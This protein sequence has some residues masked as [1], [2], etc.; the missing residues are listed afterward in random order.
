MPSCE[1]PVLSRCGLT[2]IGLAIRDHGID[3]FV[4]APEAH[5]AGSKCSG[6]RCGTCDPTELGFRKS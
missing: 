3:G 5:E 1:D 6:F 4:V 2:E